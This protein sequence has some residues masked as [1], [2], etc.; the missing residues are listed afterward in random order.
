[1]ESDTAAYNSSDAIRA[2]NAWYQAF[3]QDIEDSKQYA[4]LEIPV[5]GIGGSGYDILAMS[6]QER[7]TNLQMRKLEDCGHF[8]LAEKPVETAQLM[9]DFLG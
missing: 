2:S 5:L 6:I 9:I 3:P 7:A 4:K 8:I 1:V